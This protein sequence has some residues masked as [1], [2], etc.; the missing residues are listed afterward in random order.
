MAMSE[1]VR[2]LLFT[3]ARIVD[4]ASGFDGPSQLLTDASGKIVARGDW[5][6]S[7]AGSDVLRIN[8]DGQ[9]LMPGLIDMRVTTGEPGGEH[10]ETLRSAGVAAVAGGITTIVIQPDGDNAIDD[11]AAVDFI[12]RRGRDRSL[13]RVEVAGSLTRGNG[14]E[15]MAEIGLMAEAGARMMSA[16]PKALKDTRLL[17]RLMAYAT[18][19]DVLVSTRPQDPWLSAGG[20]A[21]AGELAARLGLSS[22]PSAAETI[23]AQRDIAIAELTGAGLLLDMVSCGDTIALIASARRRG[24]EVSASVNVH[25]LT[26]NET[27]IGDYRTFA[28]LDPPLRSEDDRLA[29][30]EAVRTGMIAVIVSG[31]D[32][33]PAEE[34]RLPFDEAAFG[35]SALETLL[36][37]ALTLYHEGQIELVDL[38]AALTCG[39][40]N[41][42]GLEQGRLSPGAPADLIQVDLGYPIHFDASHMVSKSKNSPFDGRRLQG[43]VLATWV[44]GRCVHDVGGN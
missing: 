2:P 6:E 14:G 35:A 17:R 8:C 42:L 33:R 32:P 31:H 5:L 37:A 27:D 19:H 22:I 30:I 3:N 39:P 16:G 21:H 28:K 36:P 38:M 9:A 4:P 1:P 20:V 15:Q 18:G 40:A 44:G 34:K 12:L 25:S 29:L 26:L 43:R 23:C 10:R 41:L 11:P 7:Q 24:I 13:A